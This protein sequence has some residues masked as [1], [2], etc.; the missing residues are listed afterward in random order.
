[1]PPV[2]A[3]LSRVRPAALLG[4]EDVRLNL[5]LL[6]IILIYAL[7]VRAA[8]IEAGL[9][10]HLS[11]SLYSASSRIVA[12]LSFS[13]VAGGYLVHLAVVRRAA[14]PL[15][16]IRQ[17]VLPLLR[18]PAHLVNVG[19]PL[20]VLPL[21][22][23][24]FTSFKS[25]IPGLRPFAFDSLF[26]DLDR[27]LHGGVA[28]WELTHAVFGG[29]TA[30]VAINAAYNLW[31]F[32]MWVF[33]FLQMLRI[34]NHRERVRFLVAYMLCWAVIGSLFAWLLSS[35]GP[36]YFGHVVT[37][38]VD[39]YGPLMAR[40]QTID[41]EFKAA[42]S[43]FGVWALDTQ[44]MLWNLARASETGVGG[45]ISAMPSM[46]VAIATLMALAAFRIRRWFGW[47]MAGY[48]VVIQIG[49]VHL[50]WH[51]ALDGYVAALLTIALWRLSGWMVA[52][53][54]G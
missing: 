3:A 20:L 49:S 37:N 27:V 43:Y 6:A 38:T 17:D 22:L 40:L 28:P 11:Y 19:L 16:V 10:G 14:R 33:V 36:C 48:A 45:G 23:S 1:M 47:M 24:S 29:S 31:F 26:A 8:A 12:M 2:A 18:D 53:T 42:G 4:R 50:G 52:R 15:R 25:M 9:Q 34:H 5:L 51:Y 35:A 54:A 46:H 41:Q 7:I 32:V 44:T 13:L 21:F 39:P 30:T